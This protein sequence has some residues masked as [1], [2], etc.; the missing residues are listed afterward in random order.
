[1]CP[2]GTRGQNKHSE[3]MVSLPPLLQS[4]QDYLSAG[5]ANLHLTPLLPNERVSILSSLIFCQQLFHF[6]ISPF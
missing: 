3:A 6:L 2:G 1:M 4:R 5:I